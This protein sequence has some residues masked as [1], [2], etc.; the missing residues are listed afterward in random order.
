M[1]YGKKGFVKN[2]M[3]FIRRI[4]F[5]GCK[6]QSNFIQRVVDNTESRI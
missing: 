6:G 3:I 2:M 5:P 4:H 1:T